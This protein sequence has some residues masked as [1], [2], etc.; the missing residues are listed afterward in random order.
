M[1][2]AKKLGENQTN[3]SSDEDENKRSKSISEVM[4]KHTVEESISLTEMEKKN[5]KK[6]LIFKEFENFAEDEDEFD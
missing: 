3:D 6:S 5:I 1:A 4:R 2:T